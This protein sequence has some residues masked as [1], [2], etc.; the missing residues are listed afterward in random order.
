[1]QRQAVSNLPQHPLPILQMQKLFGNRAVTQWVVQQQ[2]ARATQNASAPAQLK[3]ADGFDLIRIK[4]EFKS[5]EESAFN[6]LITKYNVDAL[7]SAEALKKL[8]ANPP[9][10]EMWTAISGDK[11][12]IKEYAIDTSRTLQEVQSR[13]R[14][15]KIKDKKSD[16]LAPPDDINWMVDQGYMTIGGPE[17]FVMSTH[18]NNSHR[19]YALTL[20]STKAKWVLH[21]HWRGTTVEKAH[22]KLLADEY[23]ERKIDIPSGTDLFT[24]ITTKG[25]R[26]V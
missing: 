25:H 11:Y 5:M 24:K 23:G 12:C 10:E 17:A 8:I 26:I 2:Q 18:F 16:W 15:A 1:M 13:G 22:V 9:T 3:K 6:D 14:L 20:G 4:R 21:A 19:R 7:P